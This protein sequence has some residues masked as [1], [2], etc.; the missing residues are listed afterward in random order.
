MKDVIT[1]VTNGIR[2]NIFFWEARKSRGL[3]LC[4]ENFSSVSFVTAVPVG[5]IDERKNRMYHLVQRARTRR[6]KK[7]KEFID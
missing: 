5:E 1:I 7:H 4:Y 6:W 3:L 2:R